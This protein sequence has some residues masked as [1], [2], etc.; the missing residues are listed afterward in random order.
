MMR[1][2]KVAAVFII[3]VVVMLV[4]LFFYLQADPPIGPVT[5]TGATPLDTGWKLVEVTAGLEH[6]WAAAWLPDNEGIL[7]TERP[8]RVR[9]FTDGK[10]VPTPLTGVPPVLAV[11][12][13][14][15]MDLKLHP[16]FVHNR[17]VYFTAATG[18]E[19][20]NRTTL[21]RATLN[22]QRT[23]LDNLEELYRVSRD[24]L[25]GQ[26]FGSVLAW[27][28]DG[29]LLMSVGD[30][31]NPPITLDG[32]LI[33]RQ[34]QNPELAFG[35][36]LR[37]TDDGRPHPD[38]PFPTGA[39]DAP[40]VYTLGH[41]NVQGIAIRPPLSP[42]AAAQTQ[43]INTQL[44]QRP[45]TTA[46]A[47]WVTEHGSKGGDELN[48]LE[49][50]A[51]YGWPNATYSVEYWGFAIA[52]SATMPGALDPHVVWTPALAPSGL[53]FYTGEAFPD[54]RGDLLAGGLVAK[55]IR[56]IH[57][58]A[59]GEIDGQTTLQV[60]QRVRWVGMGPDA[61]LYVLTDSPAGGLYRI[62]PD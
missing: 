19:D 3:A 44:A 43:A 48:R 37:M 18:S 26:H 28:P 15:L 46:P 32:S 55:Q 14:G 23:G 1:L 54:W 27:L 16:D 35:K 38:N 41:R 42:P 33:R 56:R 25:G 12:Q 60:D 11:G 34:S 50:G 8:G 7:I 52:D 30:G 47:I 57:F 2:I 62:E 22:P 29:S 45:A 51:N 20:A 40:F 49:R 61:G 58:N 36:V 21:F 9:L 6:P 17:L 59:E 4:G 5:P 53:T 10:L 24:K 31:G 39:G 13:S